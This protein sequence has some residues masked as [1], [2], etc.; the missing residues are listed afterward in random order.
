MFLEFFY[1]LSLNVISSKQPQGLSLGCPHTD[2][3]LET[4]AKIPFAH[5]MALIT[6][7]LFEV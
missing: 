1:V 4:D 3:D 7:E 6:D 2:T 5:R